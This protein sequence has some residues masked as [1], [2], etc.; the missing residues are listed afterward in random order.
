MSK[1]SFMLGFI[2][3]LTSPAG[4]LEY[5]YNPDEPVVVGLLSADNYILLDSN[6][7]YLIPKEE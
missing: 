1:A 5:P 6:G 4:V 7:V 3:G 2:A